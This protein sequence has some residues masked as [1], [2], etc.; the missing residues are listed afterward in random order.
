MASESSEPSAD[1]SAASEEPKGSADAAPGA[2]A[3]GPE[4]SEGLSA[5]AAK[6]TIPAAPSAAAKERTSLG[7]AGSVDAASP[8]EAVSPVAATEPVPADA[9][10]PTTEPA[11]TEATPAPDGPVSDASVD[12][13]LRRFLSLPPIS[14]EVDPATEPRV[15]RKAST[16][17]APAGHA[18]FAS[19]DEKIKEVEPMLAAT[20]WDAIIGALEK[21]STLPP[22]L[23]LLY[24][25]ALKER[26]AAGNPE[27]MAISAVAALLCV[28][29]TSETALVV[30]KRLLRANPVTW[31]QRRAPSTRTSIGI[32]LLVAAVGAILGYLVSPGT[33]LFR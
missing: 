30:A 32:A 33:P 22:P 18:A 4:R 1:A 17:P 28:P 26:Q 23:A 27:R 31:K 20:N 8:T 25:V 2:D 9:S 24:A 3:A 12:V 13:L 7:A 6:E 16:L 21:H 15:D 19:F 10:T 5:N 29:E 14:I 11:A